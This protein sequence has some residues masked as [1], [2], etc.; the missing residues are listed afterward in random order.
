L[1][2]S[3]TR[4]AAARKVVAVRKSDGSVV[5]KRKK[6]RY[7]E[8]QL[9]FDV[10][11]VVEPRVFTKSRRKLTRRTSLGFEV[12]EFAEM[13]GIPL[14]KWQKWV[15][16]HALEL[17]E[18]GTLRFKYIV[19]LV[20]RQNGKTT[21][22]AVLILWY[23]YVQ[24]VNL[25]L[26]TAQNLQQA[27][28]AW[29]KVAEYIYGNEWLRKELVKHNK[30]NGAKFLQLKDKQRY[31]IAAATRKSSRGKSAGVVIM[32]EAREQTNYDA[33]GAL[34][35]TTMAK[36]EFQIWIPSNAGD[37]KSV[38]LQDLKD[39][40]RAYA[41]NP[42]DEDTD[43]SFGYF[44]YAALDANLQ[45]LPIEDEEGHYFANPS[46]PE[47]MPYQNI[48]SAM[49]TDPPE[50]FRAEVLCQWVQLLEIVIDPQIWE[51]CG[52]PQGSLDNYR[53]KL[54]V[55]IDVSPDQKHVS[56]YVAAETGGGMVRVEPL[57][58]SDESRP[59]TATEQAQEQLPAILARVR[60][61][62]VVWFPGGP[63][64]ALGTFLR[65]KAIKNIE[66]IKEVQALDACAEFVVMVHARK[67]R[68]NSDPL[69]NNHVLAA[70]KFPVGDRFKF[71]RRGAGQVDALYAAAGAVF[72]CRNLGPVV[73]PARII[74]P[75]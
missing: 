42:E 8:E 31:I 23:M 70:E 52:D 27:E 53:R 73:E 72:A 26:G 14:L 35:K 67:I 34:T 40:G 64:S 17:N 7:Y 36:K 54:A 32:D 47:L 45:N 16:I 22:L 63:A 49:K 2:T 75:T 69:L 37:V 44:E 57:W 71:S 51:S 56:A 62:K 50:T 25:I 24:K 3:A 6:I 13:L 60:P 12:I 41:A 11:G 29:E 33:Y 61:R 38:V 58:A 46:C 19:L 55:C 74:L 5:I 48:I 59:G 1:K 18:D 68:H 39:K 9:I 66:E 43:L 65:G 20:A 30:V 21:L 10:E 15:L 4:T 28:E